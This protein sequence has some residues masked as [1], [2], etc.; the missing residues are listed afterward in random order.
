MI[1]RAHLLTLLKKKAFLSAPETSNIDVLSHFSSVDFS[2]KGLEEIDKIE[3]IEVTDEE[4][5]MFID[6]RPFSNASPYTVVDTMSLAKALIL[7]REVG[8]RHMLVI[9]K[10]PSVSLLQFI[11]PLCFS[12]IMPFFF[13]GI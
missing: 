11:S 2:K 1:L 5:E 10:H 13:P 3:D 4:M 9:P 12:M 8:L 6:L 7:F